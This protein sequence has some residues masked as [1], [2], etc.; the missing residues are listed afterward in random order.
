MK[1]YFEKTWW[2][3]AYDKWNY[4]KRTPSVKIKAFNLLIGM[5]FLY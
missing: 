2:R 3:L 4:N 1:F 5:L